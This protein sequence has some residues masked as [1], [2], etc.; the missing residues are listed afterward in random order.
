MEWRRANAIILNTI[1]MNLL[2]QSEVS[3]LKLKTFEKTK[4]RRGEKCQEVTEQD[5]W[6]KDLEQEEVWEWDV[7]G[8]G[9]VWVVIVPELV[10][11]AIVFALLVEPRAH[12]K[13][14]SPA[15]M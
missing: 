8:E 13:W 11:V 9:V 12:I 6:V 1:M 14:E 4:E 15:M 3:Y 2:D 10:Q 5:L 7:A